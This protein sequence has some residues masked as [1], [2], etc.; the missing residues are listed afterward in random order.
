MRWAGG[1][2]ALLLTAVHALAQGTIRAPVGMTAVLSTTAARDTYRVPVNPVGSGD[3]VTEAR[4]GTVERFTFRGERPSTALGAVE[5]V[6]APLQAA[7]FRVVLDCED[8]RCG[9]FDFVLAIDVLR[10]PAMMVNPLDFHQRTLALPA[11]GAGDVTVSILGS[12]FAGRSHLQ[13]VRVTAPPPADAAIP[14][15]RPP[16]ASLAAEVPDG[17]ATA[18]PE[19]AP[20]EPAPADTG[21]TDTGDA[22]TG[23]PVLAMTAA[24]ESTGRVILR[25]ID[26]DSASAEKGLTEAPSL[27]HAAAMLAARPDL[28]VAVVGHSDGVGGL[29]GN[30]ALSR[31]RATAVVEALEARGVA[32]DRLEAVGAGWVAPV[33]PNTSADGRAANRRVELVLR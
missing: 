27:D 19:Q 32:P 9:G 1:V 7:G 8:V 3:G 30:V 10:Q 23:D 31:A 11:A 21:D 13:V 17:E 12:R 18:L 4:V 22:D 20:P 2:A 24:L 16:E 26:F 29:D 25:G 28:Q 14:A 15:R 6:A 33:A 5:A